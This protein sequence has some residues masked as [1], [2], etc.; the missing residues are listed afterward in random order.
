MKTTASSTNIN[1]IINN[2]NKLS[3]V[4][5]QIVTVSDA[6]CVNLAVNNGDSDGAWKC[7]H[8]SVGVMNCD[9]ATGEVI[10]QD[11]GKLL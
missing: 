9:S 8:R 2:T 10:G 6:T 4:F 7:Q 5:N 11:C 1:N 3:N